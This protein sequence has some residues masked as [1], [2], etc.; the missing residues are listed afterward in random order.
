MRTVL[1]ALCMALALALVALPGC[2]AT[3]GGVRV[4][5]PSPFPYNS[6]W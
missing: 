4:E 5:N 1:V 6:R 2:N 3:T